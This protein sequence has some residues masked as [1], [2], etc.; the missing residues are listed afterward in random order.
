MPLASRFHQLVFDAAK[1]RLLASLYA[2]INERL[3]TPE[4]LDRLAHPTDAAIMHK[5]ESTADWRSARERQSAVLGC[6]W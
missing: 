4:N 2:E 1:N 5:P 3:L 6:W